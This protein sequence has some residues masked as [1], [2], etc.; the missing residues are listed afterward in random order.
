MKATDDCL[1]RVI[2]GS[3]LKRPGQTLRKDVE[4]ITKII[5]DSLPKVIRST[6]D[7][8]QDG[9]TRSIKV[10]YAKNWTGRGGC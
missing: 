2:R 9:N 10:H 4:K 5:D 8:E 6:G 7:Q 3:R 1:I